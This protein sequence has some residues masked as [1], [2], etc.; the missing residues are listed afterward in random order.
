MK[1]E[2]SAVKLVIGFLTVFVVCISGAQER[3]VEKY[4]ELKE[5]V[6]FDP[7]VPNET[8]NQLIRTGINSDDPE[9]FNLTLQ[10]INYYVETQIRDT[11]TGDRSQPNRSISQIPDLKESLIDHWRSE[12]AKHG[13]NVIKFLQKQLSSISGAGLDLRTLDTSA[14]TPEQQQEAVAKYISQQ[15]NATSPW[16]AIPRTLCV[17]WPQDDAVHS[18]IWEFHDNDRAIP[19]AN[20]L[21]LLNQGKFITQAANRYRISQLVAYPMG[22]GSGADETISLAARGLALSHPEEAI[23]NLVEAGFDH[24]EPRADVLITLAGYADSQLDPFYSKL[25]SLVSAADRSPPL[26]EPYIRALSRLAPYL[27]MPL[28]PV[29]FSKTTE[30]PIAGDDHHQRFS[31]LRNEGIFNPQISDETVISMLSEGINHDDDKVVE[32]TLRVLVEYSGAVAISASVNMPDRYPRRPVHQ[33][34]N[35]RKFLIERFR[36]PQSQ[37]VPDFDLANLTSA[38]EGIASSDSDIS[39]ENLK[40]VLPLQDGILMVLSRLWP[41]DPEVHSLIWE[42][43]TENPS[44]SVSQMLSLLNSGK[45]ATIEA[46]NYRI[47]QLNAYTQ[48]SG[49]LGDILTTMAAQGLALNHPIEALPTLIETAKNHEK[50]RATVLT[51]LSGYSKAQLEPY[52]SKLAPLVNVPRNTFPFNQDMQE[53]LDRLVEVVGADEPRS[54]H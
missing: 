32:L 42:Y 26:D 24:I 31:Y 5:S 51:T 18:L 11:S 27:K 48:E 39:M 45:F 40:D 6:I 33:V 1:D 30:N 29:E 3:S 17:L 52:L 2:Y 38:A 54:S 34:P 22:S 53:A 10:T 25:V 46:S 43:Q 47:S 12:H 13:H 50:S 20:V 49:P 19:P 23:A 21:S 28:L 14:L 41:K 7:D 8:I 4:V 35:L 15:L 9:I 44:M 36:A 16:V 37:T